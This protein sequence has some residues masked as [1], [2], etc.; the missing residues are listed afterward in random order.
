MLLPSLP[1]QSHCKT[2]PTFCTVLPSICLEHAVC[3]EPDSRRRERREEERETSLGEKKGT[4]SHRHSHCE[5]LLHEAAVAEQPSPQLH[6][7]DAEDEEDKE[8][9][10]EDVPQHGQ[11]VQEQIHKDAHACGWKRTRRS[12]CR[13]EGE[14][15]KEEKNREA[16]KNLGDQKKKK[17]RLHKYKSRV[18]EINYFPSW[19]RFMIIALSCPNPC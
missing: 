18:L 2:Q 10:Q 1:L 15:G 13:V 11:G 8:A 5:V 7:N 16:R 3:R 12:K 17:K 6:P 14:G 19:A 4:S 9:E